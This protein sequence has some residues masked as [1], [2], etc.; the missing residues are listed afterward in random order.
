MPIQPVSPSPN[1]LPGWPDQKPFVPYPYK[2][3]LIKED[4]VK[5]DLGRFG[6]QLFHDEKSFSALAES[7]VSLNRK[8]TCSFDGEISSPE[9]E[10]LSKAYEE[11]CD[12]MDADVWICD[13]V[14]YGI[15]CFFSAIY[16]CFTESKH[17]FDLPRQWM[18]YR[19]ADQRKRFFIALKDLL[20]IGPKK[21]PEAGNMSEVTP[22]DAGKSKDGPADA[23][24]ELD[25]VKGEA[26][27][28]E[29][30]AVEGG[31][32]SP[33]TIE[34]PQARWQVPKD[35]AS[36]VR[37]L[38]AKLLW[39]EGS[40][41][42]EELENIRYDND[43]EAIDLSFFKDLRAA[44]KTQEEIDRVAE[45][46]EQEAQKKREEEEKKEQEANKVKE[47]ERLEKIRKTKHL[48]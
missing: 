47:R 34:D 39:I 40:T 10:K 21:A 14:I 30:Q 37:A 32:T 4:D 7:I 25:G 9:Q 2:E 3:K 41:S 19:T 24:Q 48:S 6:L 31:E 27:K 18:A 36:N 44:A 45:K 17:S 38:V 13:Y 11:F 42:D 5:F 26:A 20:E 8:I 28:S 22:A 16:K 15:F 12:S 33:Q 23:A 43:L 29:T 1:P 35:I 46:K